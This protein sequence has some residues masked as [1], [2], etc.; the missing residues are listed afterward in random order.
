MRKPKYDKD[1]MPTTDD[2]AVL[3]WNHPD[4]LYRLA[5]GLNSVYGLNLV[6]DD[7]LMVC[8]A[9]SSIVCPCFTYCDN[10]RQLFYVL[11][12]NPVFSGGLGGRMNYYSAIL[13]MT[14]DYAW[15]C[16]REIYNDIYGTIPIPPDYDWNATQK[17]AAL[18]SLRS[19]VAQVDYFDF[20]D[21]SKPLSSVYAGFSERA[22][23]KVDNYFREIDTCLKNLILAVGNSPDNDYL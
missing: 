1:L 14:G 20:R 2:T 23:S 6:R 9:H 15:N 18:Q 3:M 7:D 17:Y 12:G 4:E 19:S 22:L 13:M 21:I 16:Q 11:V 10:M 5:I 8:T